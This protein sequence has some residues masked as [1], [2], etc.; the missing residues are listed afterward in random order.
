MHAATSIAF[1]TV[2]SGALPGSGRRGR[3]PSG[4]RP[5]ALLLRSTERTLRVPLARERFAFAISAALRFAPLD[6]RS[7]LRFRPSRHV[8]ANVST[9]ST[10]RHRCV[11]GWSL[12]VPQSSLRPRSAKN[13]Y[14]SA[15][16]CGASTRV[17][18]G[19][20]TGRRWIACVGVTLRCGVTA[21][22]R[23]A[24]R[25]FADSKIASMIRTSASPS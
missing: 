17:N 18:R 12:A 25:S 7:G 14:R 8:L 22:I 9:G 6:S 16:E 5:P 20:P 23:T 11:P 3:R 24:L 2:I 10:L 19:L 1:S 13:S 21:R 15:P 4:L